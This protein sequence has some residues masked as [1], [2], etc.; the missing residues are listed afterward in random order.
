MWYPFY[1]I[2]NPENTR[3]E[4]EVEARTKTYP[5]GSTLVGYVAGKMLTTAIRRA[6][7]S[8]DPAAVAAAMEG[9]E[10]SSP[11]G[12][13]KVRACDHMAMYNFYVGTVQK[14]A[15]LP[16]GIGVTDVKAYN[17]EKYARSCDEIARV[18]KR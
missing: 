12:P 8:S 11:V 6:K 10:F 1:A 14:N 2:D 15:G 3:F 5:V 13:V 17:T 18:R 9:L 16:D 7:D 4:K